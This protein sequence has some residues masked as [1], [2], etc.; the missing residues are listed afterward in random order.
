MQSSRF[1]YGAL[2][3]ALFFLASSC[4]FCSLTYLPS[5]AVGTFLLLWLEFMDLP[6]P[7]DLF[8]TFMD[9]FLGQPQPR[10]LAKGLK[11]RICI[12]RKCGSWLF[13]AKSYLST[14]VE[15]VFFL[16]MFWFQCFVRLNKIPL[17]TLTIFS[18]IFLSVYEA[19]RQVL[20]WVLQTVHQ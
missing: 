19:S 2:M 1:P 3:H 18:F 7:Q 20:S 17:C 9:P 11:S 8:F 6:P 16:Y 14:I 10:L 13:W 12:G 5:L 4:C 15:Y